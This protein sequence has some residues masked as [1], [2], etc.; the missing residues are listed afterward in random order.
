MHFSSI[1]ALCIPLAADAQLLGGSIGNL[2]N[3]LAPA[4]KDDLRFKNF[5]PPGSGD[6]RS[7][8]PGLNALA[9]HNFIPHDGKNNTI[10]VLLKGL[11]EGLNMGA[12]FTVAVG[13]AGLL[14]S[15]DPLSGG[16]DLND[17]DEH[18]FPIEHDASLSRQDFYFGDDHSFYAPNWNSVVSQFH[19]SK[20]DLKTAAK[21]KYS[22]VQDSE[23]RN[24][25]FTY[26]IREFIFSY[27]E[28]AIYLQTMNRPSA[29]GVAEVDYVDVLFREER[30]PYKEGWRV[31]PEP[32]TLASL[33]EQVFELYSVSPEP[34]PEGA[35]VTKDSLKDAIIAV[36][37]LFYR[38]LWSW[39]NETYADTTTGDWIC[40]VLL[41]IDGRHLQRC[42]P[43]L[44]D[45]RSVDDM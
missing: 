35:Q 2:L 16:F 23:K 10:P 33:G 42:W 14:S 30:L 24:P 29:N 12:D 3:S 5:H 40:E 13:G 1:G 38:S 39:L 41:R 37:V 21:A 6:V 32:I 25:T 45:T 4:P 31:S 11:A 7:P 20:T 9:N 18:S 36:S 34:A 8:C 22:R 27:G 43:L 28:T 44:N 19:G 26:G 15:N 17:L